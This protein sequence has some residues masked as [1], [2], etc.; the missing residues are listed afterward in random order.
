MEIDE[1]G[2]LATDSNENFYGQIISSSDR[3]VTD[4]SGG[5]SSNAVILSVT[6]RLL[7]PQPA[8]LLLS[9]FQKLRRYLNIPMI[10]LVHLTLNSQTHLVMMVMMVRIL[11]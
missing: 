2:A 3:T 8:Q 1:N 5:L 4:I 9:H 11:M 6:Q 7:S 10:A